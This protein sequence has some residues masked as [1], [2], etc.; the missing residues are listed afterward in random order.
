MAVDLNA[1][2]VCMCVCAKSGHLVGGARAVITFDSDNDG[3]MRTWA[4]SDPTI[5]GNSFRVKDDVNQ[6]FTLRVL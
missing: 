1:L 3:R 4:I 5:L 6:H 2:C